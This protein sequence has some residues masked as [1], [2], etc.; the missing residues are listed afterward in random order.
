MNLELRQLCVLLALRG[1]GEGA[2]GGG[3]GLW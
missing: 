1:E 2:R 3:V